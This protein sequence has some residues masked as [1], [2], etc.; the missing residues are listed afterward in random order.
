MHHDEPRFARIVRTH[1]II[2]HQ[3]FTLLAA[4]IVT[5]E[6]VTYRPGPTRNPRAAPPAPR[7]P[8]G[9]SSGSAAAVAAG[10]VPLACQSVLQ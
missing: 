5:I 1:A 3:I 2:L 4:L 8:G 9:S 7:T 10:M 6:F